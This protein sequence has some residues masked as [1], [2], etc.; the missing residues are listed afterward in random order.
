LGYVLGRKEKD[1]KHHKGPIDKEA[2]AR[3][4]YTLRRQ[5]SEKATSSKHPVKAPEVFETASGPRELFSMD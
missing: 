1:S 5:F 4:R 3:G 2:A